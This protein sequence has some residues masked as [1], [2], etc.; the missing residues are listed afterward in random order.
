MKYLDYSG[1]SY[2]WGKIKSYV[3]TAS[4]VTAAKVKSALG[5]TSTTTKFLRED[6]NWSNEIDNDLLVGQNV[7]IGQTEE[8]GTRSAV[9][10]TEESSPKVWSGSVQNHYDNCLYLS[11]GG[12]QEDVPEHSYISMYISG[13]GK[14]Y[15]YDDLSR[16]NG[17]VQA[18][19]FV[20]TGHSSP[21][22]TYKS[23]SNES[24]VSI[25]SGQPKA[26]T[27]ISLEAGTWLVCCNARFPASTAGSYRSANISATENSDTI[28]AQ[29]GASFSN[30]LNDL[31]FAK[32]VRPSST[33]TYY[34]NVRADAAL[35]MPVSAQQIQAVRLA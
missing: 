9:F 6:G 17:N 7:W 35:T 33:A 12:T 32:I 22:G 30:F 19:G 26:V 5:V 3:D 4:A 25:T 21:I 1:L 11:S 20:T 14:H 18:D 15:F 10:G 16:F 24:T 31:N 28:H 27:S 2:F 34:L 13:A 23:V 8:V 29:I